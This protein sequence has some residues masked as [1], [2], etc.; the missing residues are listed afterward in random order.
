MSVIQTLVDGATKLTIDKSI[1]TAMS[2]SRGQVLRTQ[3]R[4][5]SIYKF[6]VGLN[7]GLSYDNAT[8]RGLLTDYDLTGRMTSE[9]IKLG[10]VAGNQFI[11]EYMGSLS[12]AN[13]NLLSISGNAVGNVLNLEVTNLTGESATDFIVKKGDFIQPANSS[14]PYQ[15]TAD[16]LRGTD[17]TVAVPVHR[18]IIESNVYLANVLLGNN[19]TF[20]VKM[21]QQ[22]P[23]S[24]TPG[25]YVEWGG[26]LQ[27]MEDIGI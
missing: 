22:P 9:T 5:T 24:I 7:P 3:S 25:R 23:Y 27:L 11:T 6:V 13:Q 12:G 17:T 21:I 26:D 2:V 8:T 10:N 15:A 19:C 20:K 1:P 16:V 4:S 14:Y 18:E